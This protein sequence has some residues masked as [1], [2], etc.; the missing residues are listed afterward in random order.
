MDPLEEGDPRSIGAY[1]L[2]G[3][4]GSG[5]M[6]EVFLGRTG[7]GRTAAIKAARSDLAANDTLVY[8]VDVMRILPADDG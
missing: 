6:G 1:W 2:I 8:V 7:D 4:L 3:R 5:G